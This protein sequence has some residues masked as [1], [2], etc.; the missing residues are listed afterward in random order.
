MLIWVDRIISA[1]GMILRA[2]GACD[3]NL[4][5]VTNLALYKRILVY[6]WMYGSYWT[7]WIKKHKGVLCCRDEISSRCVLFPKRSCEKYFSL[8]E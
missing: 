2:M 5:V 6:T 8:S 7:V 1:G 4:F 3:V